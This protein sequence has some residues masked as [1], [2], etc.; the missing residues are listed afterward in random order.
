[1]TMQRVEG[2]GDSKLESR[3][4]IFT[5]PNKNVK[6]FKFVTQKKAM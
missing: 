1:M 4:N 2:G 5:F 6:L 3:L